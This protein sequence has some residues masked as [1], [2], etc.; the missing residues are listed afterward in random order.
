MTVNVNFLSI[1]SLISPSLTHARSV[2]RLQAAADH[3]ELRKNEGSAAAEDGE[4]GRDERESLE[5]RIEEC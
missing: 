1:H 3:D 4:E 2:P 5:S